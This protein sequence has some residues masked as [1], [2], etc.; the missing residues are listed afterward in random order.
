MITISHYYAARAYNQ[1]SD[2]L[3]ASTI[4][5]VIAAGSNQGPEV[6]QLISQGS[7]DREQSYR[8]GW[9]SFAGASFF[10]WD[11]GINARARISAWLRAMGIAGLNPVAKGE[12]NR[13]DSQFQ[14][15]KTWPQPGSIKV[16]DQTVLIKLNEKK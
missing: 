7:L 4:A 1:R 11:N 5:A 10:G 16:V 13:F 8:T 6:N 2:Q 9:Y 3:V 15:M 12:E 14:T